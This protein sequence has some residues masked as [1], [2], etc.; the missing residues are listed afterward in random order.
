M[1]PATTP[2]TTRTVVSDRPVPV[3]DDVDWSA[4]NDVIDRW[5]SYGVGVRR[6]AGSRSAVGAMGVSD[7][8]DVSDANASMASW[9]CANGFESIL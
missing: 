3:C 7:S 8:R 1:N 6:K 9:D 5:P 2:A 4:P